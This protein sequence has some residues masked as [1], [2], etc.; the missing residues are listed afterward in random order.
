MRHRRVGACP[1]EEVP[2]SE[3]VCTDQ[4]L[5]N[6]WYA[7]AAIPELRPDTDHRTRLLGMDVSYRRATDGR[8]SATA[9]PTPGADPVD[10]A[11]TTRYGYL[12][13]SLVDE[14]PPLFDIPEVAEP[15]RV[16]L[17]SATIGVNVSGPRAIENFL[18]IAHFPYVHTDVLGQEPHTEVV[19]YDVELRDGKELWAT[20]CFAYQPMASAASAK[21]AV[22]EY[23]YRVPHP[24]CALLYKTAPDDPERDDVIGIFAHPIDEVNIRAHLFLS[25]LD[26]VNT[27]TTIRRFQQGVLAQDKPIL[28]NQR[29]KRLPLD[30]R[31]ET[32]IRADKTAIAYRRWLRDLGVTYSVIAAPTAA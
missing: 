1:S 18:D 25:V 3:G 5:L 13:L 27:Q 31:A 28:E 17:N 16:T 22:V 23:A 7:I 9:H 19:E 30:P 29:P 26:D 21:P 11:T 8:T 12:W 4:A 10:I 14:P 32:P 15:D 24:Y 20:N 2:L 6:Q